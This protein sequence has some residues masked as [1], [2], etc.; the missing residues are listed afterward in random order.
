MSEPGLR[1]GRSDRLEGPLERRVKPAAGAGASLAQGGFELGP[2]VLNG[3][4]H[5]G[6][7]GIGA[8]LSEI[9]LLR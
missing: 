7:W 9:G 3:A 2:T 6:I 1:I 8:N 4:E 5:G